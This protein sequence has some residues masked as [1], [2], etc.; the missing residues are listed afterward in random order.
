LLTDYWLAQSTDG[1]TWRE[2]RV[3]GPFNYSI[4]PSARGLFLG[5]YMG[6]IS[7]GTTFVPFYTTT[8]DGNLVNR[9]DVFATLATAA[10]SAATAKIAETDQDTLTPPMRAEPAPPLP[11]TPELQKRLHDAVAR[12]LE[13]RVPGWTPRGI[14]SDTDPRPR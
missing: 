3:A 11:L 12:A 4:A 1:I 9:T 2:S 5:D 7:I 8:N 6:L 14:M 10:G 13:R